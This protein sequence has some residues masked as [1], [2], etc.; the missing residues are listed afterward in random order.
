MREDLC[1]VFVEKVVDDS[2]KNVLFFVNGECWDVVSSVVV[3]IVIV[4]VNRGEFY[5]EDM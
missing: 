5:E 1:F 4:I 2:L 3:K